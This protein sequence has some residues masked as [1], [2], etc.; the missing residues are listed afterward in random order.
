MP[1]PTPPESVHN[2]ELS[3]PLRRARDSNPRPCYRRLFSRQL[4][5][6]SPTLHLSIGGCSP[7]NLLVSLPVDRPSVSSNMHHS[8]TSVPIAL[9]VPAS[10]SRPNL[11][12][13]LAKLIRGRRGTRNPY[14]AVPTVFEA[15]P[16]I[17]PGSSSICILA[18]GIEPMFSQRRNESPYPESYRILAKTRILAAGIGIEPNR[19]SPTTIFP[20]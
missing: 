13:E 19:L 15:V 4:A 12:V 18:I 17:Q 14:L 10:Y 16:E 7:L 2:S 9:P 8:Y 1:L 6:H 3:G 11:T 20:G 5:N